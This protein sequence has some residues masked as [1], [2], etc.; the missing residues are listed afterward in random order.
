MITAFM[1]IDSLVESLDRHSD[2]RN[3]VTDSEII[4]IK[5]HGYDVKA[6]NHCLGLYQSLLAINVACYQ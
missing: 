3:D 2:V 4:P 1:L 6:L 5:T